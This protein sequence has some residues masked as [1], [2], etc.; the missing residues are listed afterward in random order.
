MHLPILNRSTWDGSIDLNDGVLY[1]LKFWLNNINTLPFR[2]L[3]PIDR[4]PD[5]IGFTD[6]SSFAGAAVTLESVNQIVH[7][8]FSD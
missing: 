3:V 8:M 2:T 6:A 5:I 7:C 4:T 1:E